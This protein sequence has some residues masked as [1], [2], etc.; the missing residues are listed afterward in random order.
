MIEDLQAALAAADVE[1]VRRS[2][3]ALDDAGRAEARRW[4]K[5]LD[6]NPWEQVPYTSHNVAEVVRNQ[7][8]TH[9]LLVLHLLTPKQAIEQLHWPKC[10]EPDLLAREVLELPID[11]RGE[12]VTRI[13]TL[14]LRTGWRAVPPQA[15]YPLVREVCAADG[16]GVPW[17]EL[18]VRGW[19]HTCFPHD[20]QGMSKVAATDEALERVRADGHLEALPLAFQQRKLSEFTSFAPV[21][22]ALVAA[23]DVNRGTV[24][25]L[26][27]TALDAPGRPSDQTLAARILLGVGLRS[28]EVP[29][30]L[31]RLQQLLATCHGSVTSRLLPLAL[32]LLSSAED[33]EE[34]TAT[35]SSR[36]EKKQR[37]DLLKALSTQDLRTRLGKD[38]VR[39]GLAILADHPDAALAGRASAALAEIGVVAEPL[40]S[41]PKPILGLWDQRIG[42]SRP[43]NNRFR[44]LQKFDDNAVNAV[45][46]AA[47]N[48]PRWRRLEPFHEPTALSIVVR[49]AWRDGPDA[50]RA[51]LKAAGPLGGGGYDSTSLGAALPDWLDESIDDEGP[52]GWWTKYWTGT[53][54]PPDRWQPVEAPDFALRH[55][56]ECLR[57][58]GR[59]PCLLSTPSRANG[60]LDLDVLTERLRA[61]ADVGFGALDLL[62]AILRLGPTEPDQITLLD[63]LPVVPPDTLAGTATAVDDAV[64]YLRDAIAAGRFL[65]PLTGAQQVKEEGWDGDAHPPDGFWLAMLPVDPA[66]LGSNL[67]ELT[68]ANQRTFSFLDYQHV[69]PWCPDLALRGVGLWQPPNNWSVVG[70]TLVQSPGPL[71]VAVH[72]SLLREYAGVDDAARRAAVDLTLEALGRRTYAPITAVAAAAGRL[73]HGRLNLTRCS[74]AWEQVFLAG[75]LYPVWN[76]A[77]HTTE[78]AIAQPRRPP[79]LADL[80]RMLTRYA[81]EIPRESE[82]REVLPRLALFA[83]EKGNTKAHAEARRLVAALEN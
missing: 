45:M 77:V 47:G 6:D 81:T 43:R 56:A 48:R 26:C 41:T 73:A 14:P 15:I 18:I 60:G 58:A 39:S 8:L 19:L 23:E 78:L 79:G 46:H 34:L 7:F 10:W 1:G 80:L 53:N 5:A 64:P 28:S 33:V 11:R 75:G 66:D 72:D 57:R 38:A 71:G 31:P 17:N 21:V 54:L 69:T 63:G 65:P 37:V 29:G 55:V 32:D 74:A 83:T 61:S 30:G 62:Q 12:I 24:I 68:R 2:L 70:A 44:E 49:W 4:A 22:V 13:G 51:R 25:D 82:H 36:P 50:V 67:N 27:L 16:L 20:W 52:P 40:S 76:V 59:V 42:D 3:A 35:I 9:A